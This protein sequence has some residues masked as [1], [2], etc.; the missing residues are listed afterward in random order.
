M[1]FPSSRWRLVEISSVEF[2][3]SSLLALLA[4]KRWPK[5]TAGY[6]T[7]AQS[8]VEGISFVYFESNFTL[9][10]NINIESSHFFIHKSYILSNTELINTYPF[11]PVLSKDSWHLSGSTALVYPPLRVFVSKSQ[12]SQILSRRSLPSSAENLHVGEIPTVSQRW[13][14]CWG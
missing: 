13:G 6:Q 11:R 12:A 5:N 3:G 7:Y 4:N 1:L 8:W 14:V 9:P 2:V 10:R